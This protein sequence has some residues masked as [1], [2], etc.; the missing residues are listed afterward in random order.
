MPQDMANLLSIPQLE[1]DGFKVKYHTGG[2]WIVTCPDNT[3]IIFV[4]DTWVTDGFP[5]M[6][7][8][9]LGPKQATI[10]VQTVCK[11]Y[12]GFTKKKSNAL[13]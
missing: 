10:L 4:N 6:K 3:E 11:N 9:A 2:Q 5:Y 8:D 1:H 7:I 13:S 12:K